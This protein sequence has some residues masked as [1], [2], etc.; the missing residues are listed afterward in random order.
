MRALLFI[1]FPQN[2]RTEKDL[3]EHLSFSHYI[4]YD[5]VFPPEHGHWLLAF[6]LYSY[7][8]RSL[9]S[10][11]YCFKW[12]NTSNKNCFLK[13]PYPLD[14]LIFKNW[15]GYKSLPQL[16]SGIGPTLLSLQPAFL[17]LHSPAHFFIQFY[18]FTWFLGLSSPVELQTPWGQRSHL[19]W[20]PLNPQHLTE[21]LTYRRI[22][23]KYLLNE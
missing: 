21:L 20:S 9:T 22:A 17:H 6:H 18:L 13:G 19:F 8:L 23:L 4:F 10:V 11:E 16:S 7:F 14:F 15:F 3:T 2:K 1:Y 12:L 5:C